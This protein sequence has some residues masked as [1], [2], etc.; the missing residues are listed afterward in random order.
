MRRALSS[1]IARPAS[2]RI[3]RN[4][5]VKEIPP[6]SFSYHFTK[7]P[8]MM[9]SYQV[10]LIAGAIPMGRSFSAFV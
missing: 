1:D 5:K 2:F 4:H 8:P 7:Y 6:L 9:A 10:L 3:F